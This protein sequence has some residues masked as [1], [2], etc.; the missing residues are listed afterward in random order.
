MNKNPYYIVGDFNINLLISE[1]SA[2][3]LNLISSYCFEPHISTPTRLN[4]EGNYS[5]LIDNIVSNTNN[6]SF[7]STIC[8]DISDHLPIYYCAYNSS[9]YNNNHNIFNNQ[10]TH[11]RVLGNLT[12]TNINNFFDKISK[13]EWTPIYDQRN[14]DNV[15]DSFLKIFLMRYNSCF[16]F[17]RKSPKSNIPKKNWCTFD[18]AKSGKIKCKLHKAFTQNPND[19]NKQNYI[20]FRSKLIHTIRKAKQTYYYNIFNQSIKFISRSTC[21]KMNKKYIFHKLTGKRWKLKLTT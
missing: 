7:S 13:E 3:F 17:L 10:T 6:E 21:T 19:I 5:S 20:S 11:A 9:N 15:Y 8:Y 2:N 16:P 1:T 12:K 18:I 14:P 4:N